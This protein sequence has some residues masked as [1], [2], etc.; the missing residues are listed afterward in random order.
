MKHREKKSEQKS[1]CER[2]MGHKA[3]TLYYICTWNSRNP[4]D[5]RISATLQQDKYKRRNNSSDPNKKKTQTTLRYFLV[6][7]PKQSLS[8]IVKAVWEKDTLS[9]KEHQWDKWYSKETMEAGR[10][11]NAIFKMLKEQLS[12]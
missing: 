10:Q 12:N 9:L 2:H 5:L 7:V 11:Q 1:E 6:K 4:T 3:L 8:K